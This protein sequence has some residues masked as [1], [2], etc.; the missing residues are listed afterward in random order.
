MLYTF[1]MPKD[2]LD[3]TSFGLSEHEA[4]A[5]MAVLE[6]GPAT[7]AEIAAKAR[8]SRPTIYD[9]LEKLREKGLVGVQTLAKRTRYVAEPPGNL[10]TWLGEQAREIE[11]KRTLFRDLLPK[12]EQ[13]YQPERR[14]KTVV[15]LFEGKYG[16][17]TLHQSYLKQY[18]TKEVLNIYNIDELMDAFSDAERI[19]S[20][21]K[22]SKRLD[23]GIHQRLIYTS[24]RGVKLKALDAQNLRE[25]KF[26]EPNVF[27]TGLNVT[28]QQEVIILR[29]FTPDFASIVIED[30]VISSAL[31]NWFNY[32]WNYI[33]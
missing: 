11:N 12:I 33:R 31:T 3:L 6:V 14:K 21:K 28:I 27:P 32:C 22:R 9:Q 30:H 13:R 17:E 26:I 29:R 8:T 7:V 5:Y 19:L 2:A 1:C 16:N 25:S 10:D 4:I 15:R 23:E 24:N 18:K 20:G